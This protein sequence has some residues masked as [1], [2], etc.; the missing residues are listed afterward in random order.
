MIYEYLKRHL[1]FFV[2]EPAY[3]AQSCAQF[4]LE[5]MTQSA[6]Q[7]PFTI[8]RIAE[9]RPQPVQVSASVN[10]HGLWSM[11]T[12]QP[13]SSNN[14][15]YNQQSSYNTMPSNTVSQK[16]RKPQ[17]VSSSSLDYNN[18]LQ[19]NSSPKQ[20]SY[21]TSEKTY[22]DAMSLQEVSHPGY[23]LEQFA[24]TTYTSSFKDMI[25]RDSSHLVPTRN[26]D[27]H[28]PGIS[29]VQ[30]EYFDPAFS[31]ISHDSLANQTSSDLMDNMCMSVDS[32]LESFIEN[33]QNMG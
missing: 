17:H 33:L 23:V 19:T 25:E 7:Y 24:N 21:N 4:S 14:H 6:P 30:A 8:S 31:S 28:C 26:D 22:K 32:E 2:T 15:H 9:M 29:V 27:M 1:V 11:T 18:P 12:N 20:S 13:S 16:V 10:H 3:D 5:P